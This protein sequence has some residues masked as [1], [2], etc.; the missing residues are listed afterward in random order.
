[1]R[2]L[3]LALA[4]VLAAAPLCSA[5]VLSLNATLTTPDATYNTFDTSLGITLYLAPGPPPV[6]T[7]AEDHFATTA[8]GSQALQLT[9]SFASGIATPTAIKFLYNGA[10]LLNYGDVDYT[11]T[12]PDLGGPSIRVHSDDLGGSLSTGTQLNQTPTYIDSIPTVPVTGGQFALNTSTSPSS[13]MYNY[14]C[15]GQFTM[16]ATAL[17]LP[18]FAWILADS[19]SWNDGAGREMPGNGTVTVAAPSVVAGVATYNVDVQIELLA[20]HPVWN[21]DYPTLAPNPFG[22]VI[23]EGTMRMSTSFTRSVILG[24]ANFDDVVDDEDASILGAHWL[25]SGVAIGWGDGDFNNDDIVNDK[26]AAI[27]AAHYGE[28]APGAAVP[29]PSTAVLL[30]GL[31]LAGLAAWRR[32]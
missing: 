11:L 15:Q 16:D 3:L 6:T 8:S 1:M 12:Y 18:P 24:D 25:Q 27:M 9:C 17:G 29:E 31:A 32:R 14:L 21:N 23:A 5:D 7:Y 28:T 26:D 2:Y 10:G 13:D 30:L 20:K 19:P 22:E 4:V